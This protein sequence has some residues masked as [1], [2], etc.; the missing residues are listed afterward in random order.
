MKKT[1]GQKILST[2]LA[3]MMLLMP[4]V[5][6]AAT[7]TCDHPSKVLR[8]TMKEPTCT[9]D[10]LGLY[11]CLNC[12]SSLEESIPALGHS[13]DGGSVTTPATCTA[14]GVKTFT[15]TRCGA[16]YTESIP[17]T[18]H[19]PEVIPGV[20][21]SCE[22]NGKTEGSR[23][24]TCGTILSAE[25]DIPATGH[26]WGGWV[27]DV[28]PNCEQGGLEYMTCQNCGAQQWRY[29]EALGHDWDEGV[30][31]KEAGNL[32]DGEIVYT[33]RRDASHTKTET[34]PAKVPDDGISIRLMMGKLRNNPPKDPGEISDTDIVIEKQPEDGVIP[35]DGS[36]LELT[37]EVS[38][39]TPDYHYHWYQVVT[40]KGK[41]VVSDAGNDEPVCR[42]YSPGTYY[43]VITD[44]LD[45]SKTTDNAVV[46]PPLSI[47]QQ[48]EN[49]NL[50]TGDTT[51]CLATGGV[52]PYFYRWFILNPD[53]TK[54]DVSNDESSSVFDPAAAKVPA[55]SAVSCMVIDKAGKW[56]ESDPIYVYDADPLTVTCTEPMVYL[57]KGE[58]A[59]F[60][61]WPQGGVEPYTVVWYSGGVTESPTEQRADGGWY[62]T[63]VSYGGYRFFRCEVTD[64]I[65]NTASCTA[66]YDYKQL[67]I[68]Q[69]P[70][71]GMIPESGEYKL[72]V[73]VEGGVEPYKF[74]LNNP[75]GDNQYLEIAG[76]ECTFTVTEPAWYDIYIEDAEE[77][78]AYSDIAV[79][80]EPEKVHVVD[81]TTDAYIMEPRG[82]AE[83][84][85]TV[86]G[87]TE[88]YSYDWAVE[89]GP[90][91]EEYNFSG[92]SMGNSPTITVAEPG[93]IYSCTITDA[94]G[95]MTFVES[96]RVYY[97]G[98]IWILRQPQDVK[99][100]YMGVVGYDLTLDCLAISN[101]DSFS[102]RWYKVGDDGPHPASIPL[103]YKGNTWK[104]S[105]SEAR[106]SGTY[107]CEIHN[108]T[109]G[110]TVNTCTAKVMI[111]LSFDK[112]EQENTSSYEALLHF[113]FTGGKGPYK[114]VVYEVR[115]GGNI[116][117]KTET[118]DSV[119]TYTYP[120]D[121]ARM[122][123]GKVKWLKFAVRVTDSDGQYCE[124]I[125]QCESTESGTP[126]TVTFGH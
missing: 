14:A 84:S 96:M 61:A 48:P 82:T 83:L 19:T 32:E 9:E 21:A 18:G 35:E 56:A 125:L 121:I 4:V 24:S 49:V 54:T 42:V 101:V 69:Q 64:K 117:L 11:Y 59:E 73:A 110:E 45:H 7:A 58:T 23:C 13:W 123:N 72:T 5:S 46:N 65:G 1:I 75:N 87:G 12:Q 36:G 114:V 119:S 105:G 6:L 90:Y 38:G 113:H 50:K 31:T 85:V 43:C 109:T 62:T 63:E 55:G 68:T 27:V 26:N 91:Y 3:A 81:Y 93:A 15:C 92:G 74:L 124:G 79:V 111:E 66:A 94:N 103:G 16:T 102:Y 95:D 98:P 60:A 57:R 122:E 30:V 17:A 41:D 97:A 47:S 77:N 112:A 67:T 52:A 2:L 86:E 37:V 120:A 53:G 34:I 115:S 51:E 28:P 104:T 40:V 25:A 126:A 33:C 76:G 22:T 80:Y 89:H 44:A 39:G 10:G 106:I 107:Y 29:G 78:Y 20:A 88:P 70:Q 116:D 99:L 118:V 100:P 71:G 8:D 108:D